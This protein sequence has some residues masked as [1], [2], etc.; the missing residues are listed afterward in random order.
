MNIVIDSNVL[1]SALIRNSSTRR[2]ILE[3]DGTFLFP[4]Q[5]LQ[6]FHKHKEEL[7]TKS[8]I[9]PE[10]FETLLNLLLSKVLI[11]HENTLEQHKTQA[12]QIVKDIDPDDA[13]FIACALAHPQSIL[14]TDDRKL[15]EQEAV[16]V[17]NTKEMIRY[18]EKLK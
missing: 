1:F 9:P 7:L 5:I 18:L 17:M 14:W 11:V 6:E 2:L 15:K 12:K 4:E 10:S 8:K 3:H 16:P 13:M